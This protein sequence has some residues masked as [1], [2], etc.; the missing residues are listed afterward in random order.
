VRAGDQ[1]FWGVGIPSLFMGLSVR[2][3]GQRW[4]VGGSGLAWW[5]HTEADTIDKVDAGVLRLDAQIYLLAAYRAAGTPVPPL[6]TA[7]S[8]AELAGFVSALSRDAGTRFDLSPLVS[9]VD[10]LR[11]AAV[12]FDSTTAALK[13]TDGPEAVDGERA[14][15]LA[16]AQHA[17]VRELVRVGYTA[18]S[19][20]GHDPAVPQLPL[21]SLQAVRDLARCPQ[22][23]HAGRVLST[24]LVRSRNMVAAALHAAA[25]ALEA[26]LP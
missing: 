5:W 14:K 16:R 7:A 8:V 3:K 21:P 25:D 19:P 17:A 12:S 10:R 15:V 13:K 1:S 9:A 22:D 2:P 20:F 6:E 18:G 4:A 11:A 26:A 23:S 24:R